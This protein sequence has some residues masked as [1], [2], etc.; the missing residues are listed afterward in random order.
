MHFQLFQKPSPKTLIDQILFDL[1]I[2]TYTL[3]GKRSEKKGGALSQKGKTN[4]S[5]S[6]QY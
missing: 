6:L 1:F 4:D 3:F 5:Y 2:T